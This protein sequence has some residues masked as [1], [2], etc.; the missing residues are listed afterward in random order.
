MSTDPLQD[1]QH[2]FRFTATT[3]GF[4]RFSFSDPVGNLSI[5]GGDNLIQTLDSDSGQ[6]YRRLM[7]VGDTIFIATHSYAP[8]HTLQISL[9]ADLMRFNQRQHIIFDRGYD[10]RN[11]VFVPPVS[12]YY[13]FNSDQFDFIVYNFNDGDPIF[14][15]SGNRHRLTEGT[16]YIVVVSKQNQNA[17]SGNGSFIVSFADV[18]II[19]SNQ[20]KHN[21]DGMFM[22]T[23]AG[24]FNLFATSEFVVRGEDLRVVITTN[25]LNFTLSNG[26]R[27]FIELQ[28][29]ADSTLLTTQT[30]R[31][32]QTLNSG[33]YRFYGSQDVL[34]LSSG[35]SGSTGDNFI[36]RVYDANLNYI[37]TH[38]NDT[39]FTL[40]GNYFLQ[41][42]AGGATLLIHTP[43]IVGDSR[44]VNQGDI[45]PLDA[46]FAGAEFIIVS[47]NQYATIVD[48]SLVINSLILH[49]CAVVEVGTVGGTRTIRF[50]I[51]VQVRDIHFA[52]FTVTRGATYTINPIFNHGSPVNDSSFTLEL[53]DQN[54]DCIAITGANTV[55]ISPFAISGR[56]FRVRIVP[57][58]NS[59]VSLVFIITIP[60]LNTANM[61]F[62]IVGSH[63]NN[64]NEIWVRTGNTYNLE[65]RYNGHCI[66]LFGEHASFS[67]SNADAIIANATGDSAAQMRIRET[68]NGRNNN[69]NL[70]ATLPDG[71]SVNRVV[72]VFRPIQ[73]DSVIMFSP[74]GRTNDWGVTAYFTHNLPYTV[75]TSDMHLTMSNRNN[76]MGFEHSWSYQAECQ[77]FVVSVWQSHISIGIMGRQFAVLHHNQCPVVRISFDES[78]YG[79]V[80]RY[81]EIKIPMA[82]VRLD[83]NGGTL[84]LDSIMWVGH[85][86][87]VADFTAT[88]P[89]YVFDGFTQNRNGSGF[90]LWL[91][92]NGFGMHDRQ[93]FSQGISIQNPNFQIPYTIYARWVRV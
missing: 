83:G 42:V 53:L 34:M 29:S 15:T 51:W 80:F 5:I 63:A 84:S 46:T 73:D 78:R 17:T 91:A 7:G 49:T 38:S 82:R 13:D 39:P 19:S 87:R 28:N 75:S 37:A 68:A 48:G 23:T 57:N 64:Q 26:R 9:S 54:V 86:S 69:A 92:P 24:Q 85:Y 47:G 33:F 21:L 65:V 77:I 44:V 41:V 60:T 71:S 62:Y 61:Q 88:R 89:G 70:V 93:L 81:I 18:T 74:Y 31:T 14:I 55:S 1:G 25:N 76:I 40:N 58:C 45:L 72:S 20:I 6:A 11:F 12:G 56:Q 66:T 22:V 30:I 67:T 32:G 79:G 59:N 52:D 3:D 10:S 2:H 16:E 4:H 35:N 36:I 8:N 50:Y 27:L 43:Q 90:V